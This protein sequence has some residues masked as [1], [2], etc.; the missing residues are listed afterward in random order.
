VEYDFDRVIER[1]NTNCTKWDR[2]GE[3]FNRQDALPLWVADMDF[4]VPKAVVEAIKERA[5]HPIYG[6]SYPPE[7]LYETIVDWARRHYGW[8]IRKEW[9][10]FTGGVIEGLQSAIQ[11]FTRP[12]D[13]VV[14]QPPVYYP[15]YR[16]IKHSGCQIVYNPLKLDNG[17]YTMDLEGLKHLFVGRQTFPIHQPRIKMLILCSPHNP[18]GRVWTRDELT[19]LADICINN[20]VILV[21]DELHCDLLF[22]DARHTVAATLSEEVAQRTITFMGASKSFNLAGLATSYA[23]IPN[24]ELRQRLLEVRAVRNSGNLFGWV[25][26]EAAYRYG[27][28]YLTELR[29]YLN[30]NLDFFIDYINTRIPELRV[31]RPEG[32]YLC[33]VDMRG[34]G[35]EPLELQNFIRNEARLALDDGFA[36]G[37][38]GEGFQRFN[39][40]CPRSILAEALGRLEAAVE[41]LLRK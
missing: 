11:A 22:H 10:I 37:P 5:N 39:L 12:G 36:F 17:R 15:F 23:I 27:D 2:V 19:R 38:G 40:A 29:Q 1:R 14:V 24:P 8:E 34:L 20:N 16:A 9:I 4:P 3:L 26:M 41:K 32:T 18:V 13:E 33:W 35:L 28:D 7:S 25:A 31:I 30:G 21:S 6:Y